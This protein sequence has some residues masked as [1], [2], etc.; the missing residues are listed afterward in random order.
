MMQS[1]TCRRRAKKEQPP[2][3]MAIVHTAPKGGIYGGQAGGPGL[4]NVMCLASKQPGGSAASGEVGGST[5]V[6][7]L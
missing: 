3:S 1:L 4:P 5:L 7:A 6:T 2:G